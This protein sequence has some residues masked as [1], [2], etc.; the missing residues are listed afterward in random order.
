MGVYLKSIPNMEDKINLLKAEE[1]ANLFYSG[2]DLTE[3]L[4]KNA[5]VLL[6]KLRSDGMK[7]NN[8][9]YQDTISTG[10]SEFFHDYN[11]EFHAYDIPCS[12]DYPLCRNITNLLGV[13]FIYEY[14]NRLT[15]EQSLLRN[16]Q[17]DRVNKL[18]K[19]YDKESEHMLL[20]LFELVLTNAIGCELLEKDILELNIT[21]EERLWLQSRWK[22]LNTGEIKIKLEDALK[23][24]S[25]KLKFDKDT[26]IYSQTVLFQIAVRFHHN[27]ETGTLDKLLLSFTER[28]TGDE[29]LIDNNGMADEMLRKVIDEI[30]GCRL[31][32]HKVQII[33]NNVR[34]I[35]D[36]EALLEEC[37][38]EEEY[39]EVY[40]LLSEAE[41][42]ILKKSIWDAAGREDLVD[43]DYLKDWQKSLLKY[44]NKK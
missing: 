38:Y 13:E 16:F 41:R 27:L 29:V 30:R 39:V 10:L 40:G 32:Y 31:V 22:G 36:M 25:R 19:G 8:Y 11:I 33:H 15:M 7:I 5:K 24:V 43:S 14:L 26:I 42:C 34:S 20:N 6:D 35:R 37:F 9:A 44:D 12:I 2:M 3:S 23:E 1:M 4:V 21:Q 17:E 18:L 28:D